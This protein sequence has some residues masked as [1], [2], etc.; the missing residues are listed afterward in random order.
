MAIFKTIAPHGLVRLADWRRQFVRCGASPRVALSLA[1]QQ[2]KRAAFFASRLPL[3]PYLIGDKL[4][5]VVDIG[6]NIGQWSMAFLEFFE[7]SRHICVEPNPEAFTQLEARLASAKVLVKLVNKALG[8]CRGQ[9][10]LNITEGSSLA[11]VLT[12]LSIQAD[13]HGSAASVVRQVE[14]KQAT[15]D[16]ILP[17]DDVIDL[18]KL[19]V[20]GYE[21]AVM[22]GGYDAFGRTRAVLVELSFEH[23]YKG[24]MKFYEFAA[25]LEEQFG[26]NFWD[27]AP[28]ERRPGGRAL[29]TDACFVNQEMLPRNE[30]F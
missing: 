30:N 18:I 14:I 2:R 9:V 26:L 27:M 20:Q 17:N 7:P 1:L 6:A 29:W 24:D 5:T 12:P 15:L 11:S 22:E 25:F 28:P 8:A 13:W 10:N 21:R 23:H 16:G 4:H 3:L 19:D